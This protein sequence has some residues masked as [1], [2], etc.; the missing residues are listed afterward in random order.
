MGF[1]PLKKRSKFHLKHEVFSE[2]FKRH[3]LV[4][5]HA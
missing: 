3:A 2:H 5:Y 4:S 1:T